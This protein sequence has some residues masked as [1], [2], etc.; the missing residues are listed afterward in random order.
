[1]RAFELPAT[2]SPVTANGSPPYRGPGRAV[3]P[4]GGGL[5]LTNRPD[6]NRHSTASSSPRSSGS[7]TSGW[8]ARRSPTTTG[9]STSAATAASRIRTRPSTTP[10]GTT[11]VGEIVTDGK[12]NGGQ[13]AVFSTGS[14]TLYWVSGKWQASANALYQLPAGFEIAGNLYAR[15]GYV[16]PINF[17]LNNTFADTVLAAPVG[18][19]R[20]PNIW[21]LDFRLAKNFNLSGRFKAAITADAFNVLN[22]NTTLRQTDAADSSAFNRIEEIPNPRLI[23]FGLRLSF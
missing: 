20:L 1:M 11:A 16:R 9:R 8:R 12:Q 3:A 2:D 22:T 5:L 10:T 4:D 17:T 21:N 18:D 7:P 23:R 6:Y 15:D 19:N 13:I 14:G